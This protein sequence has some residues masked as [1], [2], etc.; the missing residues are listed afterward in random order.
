MIK[1]FLYDKGG[2]A[3]IEE[4]YQALLADYPWKMKEG[5]LETVYGPVIYGSPLFEVDSQAGRV[6]LRLELA[7]ENNVAV[8][9]LKSAGKPMTRKQLI[10]E[11]AKR[12]G[13]MPKDVRLALDKDPQ[14]VEFN[15]SRGTYY[16]LTAWRYMNDAAFEYLARRRAYLSH[17]EIVEAIA[18]AAHL[19]PERVIFWPQI[20]DRFVRRAGYWGLRMWETAKPEAHQEKVDTGEPPRGHTDATRVP[21]HGAQAAQGA[22]N[23]GTAGTAEIPEPEAAPI[24]GELLAEVSA[25]AGEIES[26]A[27]QLGQSVLVQEIVEEVL[28]ADPY[29]LHYDAYYR[30]VSKLLQAAPRWVAVGPD[31]WLLR[32]RL[33]QSLQLPPRV[34]LPRVKRRLADLLPEGEAFS[35][36]TGENH[37][38]PAEDPDEDASR[39]DKPRSRR[40]LRLVLTYPH[41]VNGS[42][43][44]PRADRAFFPVSDAHLVEVQLQDEY[45]NTY[46]AWFD[47][48]TGLLHGLGPWYEE[49]GLQPGSVF[50]LQRSFAAADRFQLIHKGE[51]DELRALDQERLTNLEN[52][53]QRAQEINLPF[54]TILMDVMAQYPEGIHY[55]DLVL[56]VTGIRPVAVSTLRNLLSRL[57]CFKPKE[58]RSGVW[59]YDPSK[60]QQALR[61]LYPSLARRREKPAVEPSGMES[62][63]P[64]PGE[65][66]V[67]SVRHRVAALL[68]QHPELGTDDRSLIRAYLAKFHGI[69]LGDCFLD[70][71]VPPPETIRRSRQ[72][73]QQQEADPGS[74]MPAA[75]DTVM[76]RVRKLLEEAPPGS[77][78][79]WLQAAYYSRYHDIAAAAD[80]LRPDVPS[81]ESIRRERQR[82]VSERQASESEPG[83]GAKVEAAENHESTPEHT[84]GVE[85]VAAG[86]T[87][88]RQKEST[89]GT[90]RSGH[91]AG[92]YSRPRIL[93]H[94]ARFLTH[95]FQ[96]FRIQRKG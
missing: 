65:P 5:E 63:P 91:N 32:E 74:A 43:P 70:P 37:E 6:R 41:L 90:P 15:G 40:R 27:R 67:A 77:G 16:G 2:S 24:P 76:G 68:E 12:Q 4:V 48:T 25:K 84:R 46:S 36:D 73:L 52:L 58:P 59:V 49:E 3:T 33:P 50:Y 54:H 35:D 13:C 29:H 28:G 18:R 26:Y 1:R 93:R 60:R 11:V 57:P 80:L 23:G 85:Q 88:S 34:A 61:L 38:L 62:V 75:D 55:K 14:F 45:Y 20:D 87:P 96:R 39:S 10:K 31:R 69:D 44:I 86:A 9:V 8:E 42:I 53:R 94:L 66:E 7:T 71:A 56:L 82:L 22:G 95:L 47:R 17:Q 81:L 89:E 21:G 64:N 72:K 83:P 92:R 30:A 19:D 79:R 78:D 51:I